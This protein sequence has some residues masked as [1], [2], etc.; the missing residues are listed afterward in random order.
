[1]GPRLDADL[2]EDSRPDLLQSVTGILP[3]M[4][5]SHVLLG[6]VGYRSVQ[7]L[8]LA[9]TNGGV[10]VGLWPAE[11]KPH[12]LYLY[13][14]SRADRFVGVADE[15]GWLV[16]PNPHIA[17]WL[18]PVHQRL[19]LD[20]SL[21]LRPYVELWE[22]P[23]HSWI[24]GHL[25]DDL[26]GSLWPWLK[27]RGLA[28]DADDGS[29]EQFLRILASR[30]QAHLRAGLYAKRIW[31]QEEVAMRSTSLASEIRTEVNRLLMAIGEPR[32]PAG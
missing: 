26:D 21:E 17:F 30:P 16:Q 18:A 3:E 28:S 9:E 31:S 13:S 12:A 11:L 32:L 25:R 22:G 14:D 29:F 5:G 8:V 7:R 1:M 20:P 27:D 4:A 24:G 19:Y 6:R 15:G 10:T 2:Y 23:G